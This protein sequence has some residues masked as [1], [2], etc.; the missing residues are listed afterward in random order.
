[1][2]IAKI[3]ILKLKTHKTAKSLRSFS[4]NSQLTN[5]AGMPSQP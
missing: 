5:A 1:M 2:P 3:Q 4:Q